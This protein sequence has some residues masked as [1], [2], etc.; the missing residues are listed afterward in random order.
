[1]T[2]DTKWSRRDVVKLLSA[3]TGLLVVGCDSPKK[4]Q[5]K[6][7]KYDWS[8][9][10][11]GYAIDTTKCIGCCSCMRACRAENDVP[12]KHFRTWVERY[13]IDE[14]GSVQVDAATGG[15]YVFGR[16]VGTVKKAFFVPKLCNHC[17]KSV[18]TQVCP[19]G[20]SYHT[21]DGVVLVDQEH[22]VGCGYCVQAC[23]YGCRYIDPRNHLASKC[24]LCYHRITRAVELG[25]AAT[26]ACVHACPT[27]ARVLG[28]LKNPKDRLS[29]LL[30]Q[31]RHRMLRPEMGTHPKCYYFGLDREV[32]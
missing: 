18:C 6:L 23:P 24:T 7:P 8:K 3:G 22:C 14:K 28:N 29:L 13:R 21:K 10:Y 9:H 2:R 12:K 17:E 25:E 32:I 11:W 16:K 26:T 19:V 4:K 30:K 27:G 20:A 5:P 31:Q 1:M 15:N